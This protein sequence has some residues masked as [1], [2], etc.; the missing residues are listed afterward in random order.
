MLTS[1]LAAARIWLPKSALH[2][3]FML[4]IVVWTFPQQGSDP[5]R[6]P[7]KPFLEG[8]VV[9]GQGGEPIRKA[10]VQAI[11]EA[12]SS[13]EP[14]VY[15]A[16]T[17]TEGHFKLD[18]MDAGRY[19]VFVEKTG[20][21]GTD[22]HHHRSEG[23][24]LS[25]AADKPVKDVVLRATPAAAITGRVV[26]E[27][28]DPMPN[29]SVYVLRTGYLSCSPQLDT[30]ASERTNDLGEYRVGGLPPGKYFVSANPLPGYTSAT[31]IEKH[32]T[33]HQ[34]EMSYVTTYYPGTADAAQAAQV[35][36]HPGETVPVDFSLLRV[37]SFR[38]RGTVANL[39]ALAK[40]G[41]DN[42]GIIVLR[43]KPP[44][45][46]SQEGEIG[47]DG[48]FELRAV[49]P[50]N[51]TISALTASGGVASSTQVVE[52]IS[53]DI[54]GLLLSGAASG[55]IRGRLQIEGRQ[56]PD[57]SGFHVS[58]QPVGRG[59]YLGA[60]GSDGAQVKKNGSFELPEVPPG[61]YEVSVVGDSS[62]AGALFVKHV[63][64]GGRDVTDS[65]LRVSSGTMSIEVIASSSTADMDGSVVDDKD[66][67]AANATVV[68]VPSPNRRGALDHYPRALTDQHGRFHI[69][70]LR[71]DEY[72]ILAWEDVP[73]G[74]WCDPD[75]LKSSG[76]AG[77]TVKVDEGGRQTVTLKVTPAQ[78][79]SK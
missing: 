66:Q 78:N 46:I 35:E 8:T 34:P 7:A 28:G 67:P 19:R 49:P 25:V 10:T 3:A 68:A 58:I 20:F 64:S 65:G 42:I 50:G 74:A 13:G 40:A 5:A 16:T 47:A 56:N 18:S 54:D 27:D 69:S 9:N 75:F 30:E 52:V 71:P 60:I 55:D 33:A 11:S 37:P 43:P 23:I 26:D 14:A 79:T 15:T 59:T 39:S 73:E 24:E 51:Y 4:S 48:K 6:M 44:G 62:V 12:R 53:S 31:D 38:I 70:G 22:L 17:D 77:Q 1:A 41:S 29:V 45:T 76:S 2:V 57:L 63:R 72:S 21:I 36:L 61:T 32:T